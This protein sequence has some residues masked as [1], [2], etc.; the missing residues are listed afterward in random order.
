VN[1]HYNKSA[2]GI[3]PWT[4]SRE[5]CQSCHV[6]NL[7]CGGYGACLDCHYHS[8]YVRCYACTWCVEPG[9]PVCVHGHSF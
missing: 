4:W 8:A 7:H 9:A 1:G 3:G 2:P 5:F 6:H